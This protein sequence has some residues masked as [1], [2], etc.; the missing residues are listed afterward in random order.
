MATALTAVLRWVCHIV[1]AN[2]RSPLQK[3]VVHPN[4]TRCNWQPESTLIEKVL[5]LAQQQGRSPEAITI[6]TAKFNQSA[7]RQGDV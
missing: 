5:T 4:E 7:A 6:E 3:I 2:G 1:G